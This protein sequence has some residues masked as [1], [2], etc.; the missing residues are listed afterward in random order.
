MT[1][2][3]TIPTASAPAAPPRDTLS[4]PA[5]SPRDSRPTPAAR[6]VAYLA[7]ELPSLSATF[8]YN[9]ILELQE[10][11]FTVLPYSVHRPA[12]AVSDPRVARLR[13]ETHIL[14]SRPITAMLSALLPNLL[15]SPARFLKATG[16]LLSDVLFS[17]LALSR[18]P[19]LLYQ[20]LAAAVLA[21]DLRKK[22][23]EHLHIHFGHVP[24]QIGM[25]AAALAG[26]PFTFTTHAN[27]IFEHAALYPRKLQR[28]SAMVTISDYNRR[29]L[30]RYG[31]ADKIHVLH[32]G[33]HVPENSLDSEAVSTPD[34][35]PLPAQNVSASPVR[36]GSLGRL[37]E[38]KGMDTLIDAAAALHSEGLS[39]RIEIAGDG[40]LMESLQK[41]VNTAGLNSHVSFIGAMPHTEVGSWMKQLD[42][43]ALA[44][45]RDSSGDQDGIPVVLME[46]MNMGVP[47]ATTRIS[48]I[49]ELVIS[50]E[51]GFLSEPADAKAFADALRSLILSRDSR[52]I[53][54]NAAHRIRE[55]FD[56][57]KNT[58]NLSKLF[59]RS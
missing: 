2:S 46:A 12:A 16:Q 6:R 51:T 24:T 53:T 7:P 4:A 25:Y 13:S 14:Y 35:A 5:A 34:A 39:F 22:Q 32:C 45:R 38:K 23:A 20:F 30:L 49:P 9:E 52:L 48:G 10:L 1:P 54:R 31:H 28:S 17:D 8:V 41:Q 21:A 11:G 15:S 40:P 44:C 59:F 19:K 50:G 37:V 56:I 36:I 33:V 57:R 42:G 55:Q 47:V 29:H 43:F 27:D 58:E 18:R 26:I 3:M